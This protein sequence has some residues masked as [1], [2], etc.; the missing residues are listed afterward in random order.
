MDAIVIFIILFGFEIFYKGIDT[1]RLLRIG[2]GMLPIVVY[3]ISNIYFFD[4]LV[5]ISGMAK[6]VIEITSFHTELLTSLFVMTKFKIMF[7][8]FYVFTI[9]NF[10]KIKNASVNIKI[11]FYT[12]ILSLPIYYLQTSLR[13]DWPIWHWYWYPFIISFFMM[14]PVLDYI[15]SKFEIKLPKI[16]QNILF[17]MIIFYTVILFLNMFK[18]IH[19]YSPLHMAGMKISNF[20]KKNPGIYAMGD[21]AGIVGFLIKSPLVQLEGLV[22]DKKYLD[23]LEEKDSIEKVLN[24]YNVDYYIGTDLKKLQNDCYMIVEPVQSSGYSR[25]IKSEL[26]WKEVLKFKIGNVSTFILQR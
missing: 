13:S 8:F 20:E 21:R 5:P 17:Y 1:K 12:A 6:S 15:F 2:I 26:C 24:E 16:I 18:A 4:I 7:I 25:Q 19:S 23:L 11:F 9:F 10:K 3:V 14:G 22:M